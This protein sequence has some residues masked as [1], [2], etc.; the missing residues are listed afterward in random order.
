MENSGTM[1][2]INSAAMKWGKR[3][4]IMVVLLGPVDAYADQYCDLAKQAVAARTMDKLPAECEKGDEEP[5]PPPVPVPVPPPVPTPD[6]PPPKDPEPDKKP[7]EL[8]KMIQL[9]QKIK[10]LVFQLKQIESKEQELKEL[11][12]QFS[13]LLDKAS[14]D[15]AEKITEIRKKIKILKKEIAGM[16][17]DDLEDKKEAL[18]KQLNDLKNDLL[19][20]GANKPDSPNHWLWLKILGAMALLGGGIVTFKKVRD[21][22]DDAAARKRAK[23]KGT[24]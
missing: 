16:N 18:Q 2:N 13:K 4:A 19:A 7:D 12:S 21:R 3:L 11:Q 22:R 23:K 1:G 15:N 10:G 9:T 5:T 20:E 8:D 17:K 24:T 14:A 6:T